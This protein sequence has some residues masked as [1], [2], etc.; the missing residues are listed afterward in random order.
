M[1]RWLVLAALLL[2]VGVGHAAEPICSNPSVIF[3]DDFEGGA[4]NLPVVWKDGLQSSIT[5]TSTPANVFSGNNAVQVNW[6]TQPPGSD[7]WMARWFT[8]DGTPTAPLP[9]H[10]HVFARAYFKPDANWSCAPNCFKLFELGGSRTDTPFSGFGTAGICPNGTDFFN[11]ITSTFSQSGGAPLPFTYGFYTYYPDMP[12]GQPI[13]SNFGQN[14]YSSPPQSFPLG[15]YTCIELEVLMNTPGLHDGLQRI[16]V[17]DV[18]AGQVLNMRWRDSTILTNDYFKIDFSGM[19]SVPS[20]MWVDNVVA[21]TQRIGC[22]IGSTTTRTVRFTDLSTT[23][24]GFALER[25]SG[26]SCSNFSPLVS[27]SAV[28]NQPNTVT[29]VDANSP[30]AGACYRA[31]ATLAGSGDS[32]YTNTGC[33]ASGALPATPVNFRFVP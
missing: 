6:N 13:G 25:C 16:W 12:C 23:E 27:L 17:N 8:A 31:K 7:V 28:S 21:S 30:V 15:V 33:S 10:D 11:A 3:C 14:I 18:L 26:V 32:A 5:I 20:H 1:R 19:P 22:S 9:V 24:D 2:S 4:A 29:F